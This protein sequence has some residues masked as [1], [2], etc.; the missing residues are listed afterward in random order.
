MV[1]MLSGLFGPAQFGIISQCSIGFTLQ[2]G[3][4]RLHRVL[5]PYSRTPQPFFSATLFLQQ[6]K[7]NSFGIASN[8][9]LSSK[10]DPQIHT[11][12]RRNTSCC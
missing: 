3:L 11:V 12:T 9:A 1:D 7:K 5:P 4:S 2:F 10:A 6:Q 8:A